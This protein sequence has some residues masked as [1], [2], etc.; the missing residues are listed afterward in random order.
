MSGQTSID[1]TLLILPPLRAKHSA[2]GR[3]ILPRKFLDGVSEYAKLWQGRVAVAMTASEATDWSL[4]MVEANPLDLPFEIRPLPPTPAAQRDLIHSARLVFATLVPRHVAVAALC[5]EER[6]PVAYDADMPLA[7]REG[8][9][10]AET[11]N[12]LL[13]WRR[14]RWNCRL[15]A[16]YRSAL[17]IASGVQCNGPACFQAYS[18]FTPRP[19]LYLNT[20]VRRDMLASP[21]EREARRARLLAGQPLNLVFSGRLTAMKGVLDL[22]RVAAALKE[23]HVAFTLSI[24]GSGE[25]ASALEQASQVLQVGDCVRIEGE[26]PFQDLVRRVARES[27]LFVC[28]HP[29]G[30]PSTTFLE[31]MSFG[32]PLVGYDTEGLRGILDLAGTGWLSPCGNPAALA[33]RIADLDAN[34]PALTAAAERVYEFAR[35]RTFE[36]TMRMR[37]E[38]LKRCA[39]SVSPRG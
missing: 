26:V 31:T 34:R 24:F 10:L 39:A 29:Q 11:R 32:V 18:A 37:V 28:C 13:R 20:R 9:I 19:F 1:N 22:P 3:V 35:R 36:E 17:R 4:D 7:A 5:A 8:T 16:R 27:D 15:E 33:A 12:P 38:H 30:D 21:E 25:Q 6:V 23:R 14:R 2:A